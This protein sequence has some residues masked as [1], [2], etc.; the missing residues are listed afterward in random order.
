MSS[1]ETNSKRTRSDEPESTAKKTKISRTYE[2]L[3][4]LSK[5]DP[6][7]AERFE[8]RPKSW[9]STATMKKSSKA[10]YKRVVAL[11]CEMCVTISSRRD[12]RDS[13]ALV[14]VTLIDGEDP[15]VILVDLIVHQ[16]PVGRIIIDYKTNVHGLTG[17][18]IYSS[19]IDVARARKE[20]LKYMGPDT[21]LVGHSVDGDLASM[22]I[23][24]TN[25]IDTALIYK[26]I[27]VPE[28]RS[29]PGLRDLTQQLLKIEM[30]PIHDS[31]LDAKMTMLAATYA[32]TNPVGEV[33]AYE[34]PT[35]KWGPPTPVPMT[36]GAPAAGPVTMPPSVKTN[37]L[38]P[39]VKTTTSATPSAVPRQFKNYVTTTTSVVPDMVE[40]VVF[41]SQWGSSS[42]IFPSAAHADLAFAM[43]T[44]VESRDPLDR[45]VKA[46]EITNKT[47]TVFKKIKIMT[48]KR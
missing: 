5:A 12:D 47:G 7:F 29:T 36:V 16:P 32:L 38:P 3:V 4:A 26:R 13:K 35:S 20:V 34:A 25:V 24:H 40:N 15:D 42:V 33:I 45:V 21:I 46:V 17:E 6:R 30:P 43:L 37:T 31:F 41:K 27:D 8:G 48:A 23:S 39:S 11:D 19:K 9:V 1:P 14:R 28:L 44:G 10:Q 18:L 2:D 22:Q